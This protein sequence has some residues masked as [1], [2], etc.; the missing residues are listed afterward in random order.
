MLR[1]ACAATQGGKCPRQA[2]RELPSSEERAAK[3]ARAGQV[4]STGT[5]V[6]ENKARSILHAAGFRPCHAHSFDIHKPRGVHIACADCVCGAQDA[7]RGDLMCRPAVAHEYRPALKAPL[8][9]KQVPT[10]TNKGEADLPYSSELP[11]PRSLSPGSFGGR[12]AFARNSDGGSM[13]EGRRAG[14]DYLLPVF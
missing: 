13:G 11:A 1:I 9:W 14:I 5:A 7:P 10:H 3:R 8:P 6:S 12:P 2:A 4:Q